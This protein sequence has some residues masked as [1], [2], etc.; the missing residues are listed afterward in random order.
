MRVMFAEKLASIQSKRMCCRG[1]SF[2]EGAEKKK[3]PREKP[4]QDK[5]RE[6]DLKK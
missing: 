3:P 5:P 1:A 2:L 4:V 6:R